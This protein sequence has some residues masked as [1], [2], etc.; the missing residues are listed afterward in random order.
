MLFQSLKS[1]MRVQLTT[2]EQVLFCDSF[3]MFKKIVYNHV[4]YL[5]LITMYAMIT[6]IDLDILI[7]ILLSQRSYCIVL[8]CTDIVLYYEALY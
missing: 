7:L 5:L 6:I 4:F 8:Y 2:K 1:A 3:L